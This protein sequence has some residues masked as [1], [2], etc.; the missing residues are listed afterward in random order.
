VP[1]RLV[2]T[3]NIVGVTQ[4]RSYVTVNFIELEL[5]IILNFNN[6]NRNIIE[7]VY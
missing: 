4:L 7:R 5:V 6:N 3:M 1:A 2:A